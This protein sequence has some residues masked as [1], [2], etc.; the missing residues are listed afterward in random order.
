MIDI[1]C[2]KIKILQ[3]RIYVQLSTNLKIHHLFSQANMNK[4]LWYIYIYIYVCLLVLW[5]LTS[6]SRIFQ[7]YRGDQFYWWRKLG[8][9]EKTTNLS[10]LTDKLY[11]IMLYTSPWSRF[12]LTTSVVI[13]TGCIGS[14]K[15]KYH[16]ITAMMALIYTSSA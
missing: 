16:T 2:K 11:H 9:P 1:L 5:C 13:S 15:S 4:E 10:Q 8:N 6:L 12:K 3:K 14:C 7:L